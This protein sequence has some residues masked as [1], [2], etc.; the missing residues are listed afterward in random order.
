[1]KRPLRNGSP[2][3]PLQPTP[4][5]LPPDELAR[6]QSLW[7]RLLRLTPNGSEYYR[8]HPN[9][10]IDE[11]A[12]VE[13][14]ERHHHS[15]LDMARRHKEALDAAATEHD[16]LLAQVALA[17]GERDYLAE[18]LRTKEAELAETNTAFAEVYEIA[19]DWSRKHAVAEARAEAAEAKV[20]GLATEVQTWKDVWQE[21]V[22]YDE[23]KAHPAPEQTTPAQPGGSGGGR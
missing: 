10:V 19:A 4:T 14:L 12:V 7:A 9:Y 3:T 21:R 13:F 22:D 17:E 11:T 23:A 1:M 2:M 6:W 5:P 16:A 8:G 18:H 20:V 15:K